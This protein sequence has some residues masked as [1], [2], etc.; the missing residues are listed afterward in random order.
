MI[1]IIIMLGFVIIACCWTYPSFSRRWLSFSGR[2]FQTVEHCRTSRWRHHW[3]LLK[4]V[5]KTHFFNRY[6]PKS[7]ALP[8]QWLCHFGYYNGDLFTSLLT[9]CNLVLTWLQLVSVFCRWHIAGRVHYVNLAAVAGPRNHVSS[10]AHSA[11]RFFRLACGNA[12]LGVDGCIQFCA[13]RS[14]HARAHRLANRCC[15]AVA[16]TCHALA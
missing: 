13:W 5:L 16:R 14:L 3:L 2:R 4:N 10:S 15:D 6:F 12:I 1:I 8:A 7:P 11:A 9:C